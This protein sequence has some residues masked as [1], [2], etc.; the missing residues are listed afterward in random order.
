MTPEQLLVVATF[1]LVAVTGVYVFVSCRILRANEKAVEAMKEQHKA[2]K[3]QQ[4]ASLRPYI[5]PS[6]FLVPGNYM[7]SLQIS[8]VGKSAAKDLQLNLDKDYYPPPEDRKGGR[9]LRDAYIFQNKV[10]TF[11]PG[12]R[13]VFYLGTGGQIFGEESPRRP[14]QF[15]ITATYS[16]FGKTVTEKTMIDLE[17]YLGS[18][19]QPQDAVVSQLQYIVE[20]IKNI[21][22]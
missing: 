13:R 10:A 18:Q 14:H 11:A 15:T 8:N 17:T 22:S 21:R 2:M 9:S 5:V 20:A 4:E 1:L 7:I 3:E 12:E 16:F 19:L 6:T